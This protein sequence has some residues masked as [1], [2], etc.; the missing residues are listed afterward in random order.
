MKKQGFCTLEEAQEIAD[1][2]LAAA[3]SMVTAYLADRKKTP[4]PEVDE[5]LDEVQRDI[6]TAAI[7]RELEV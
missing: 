6:V 3:K 1:S 2:T 4:D 7:K 5:I